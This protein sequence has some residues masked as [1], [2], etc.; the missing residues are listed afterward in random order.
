MP[1][2]LLTF[3]WKRANAGNIWKRF[4]HAMRSIE[5]QAVEEIVE[6]IVE[7]NDEEK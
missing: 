2:F 4:L 3:V 5:Y 6:E 1:N 7:E